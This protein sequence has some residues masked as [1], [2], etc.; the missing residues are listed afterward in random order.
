MTCYLKKSFI[1]ASFILSVLN[2]NAQKA[3][4]LIFH[5]GHPGKTLSQQH[6][7]FVVL[8]NNQDT[9]FGTLLLGQIKKGKDGIFFTSKNYPKSFIATEDINMIRLFAS[10]NFFSANNYT[11]YKVL[12]DKSHLLRLIASEKLDIYDELLFLNESVG[13]IGTDLVIVENG[14]VKRLF[15]FWAFDTKADLL[16]FINKR[17]NTSFKRKDFKTTRALISYI[18]ARG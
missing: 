5:S 15:N 4:P 16:K 17:Y 13:R 12:N 18:V 7:G 8:K 14:N 1:F 3:N 6:E 2:L 11:D 9:L 10:D